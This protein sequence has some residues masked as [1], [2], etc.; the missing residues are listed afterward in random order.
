VPPEALPPEAAIEIWLRA[1]RA[2]LCARRQLE[3]HQAAA[4][5]LL[6][7]VSWDRYASALDLELCR[8]AADTYLFENDRALAR[9][10]QRQETLRTQV[11]ERQRAFRQA[12]RDGKRQVDED[13]I[14]A[15]RLTVQLLAVDAQAMVV[16]TPQ[17]AP[18]PDREGTPQQDRA[19]PKRRP[20]EVRVVTRRVSRPWMASTQREANP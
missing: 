15:R 13:F 17:P 2:E 18:T 14:P 8:P 11:L 5:L 1:K 9:L 4:D 19:A 16:D 20:P 6:T 3:E 10:L 12:C 7:D